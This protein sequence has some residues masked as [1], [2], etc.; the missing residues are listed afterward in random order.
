MSKQTDEQL[1]ESMIGHMRQDV[2]ST[3]E[4]D[5]LAR[6]LGPL[7]GP[8]AG[9]PGGTSAH[10][11]GGLETVSGTV[12]AV[13]SVSGFKIAATAAGLAAAAAVGG[14]YAL[15]DPTPPHVTTKPA[16]VPSG[17]VPP[18][19]RTSPTPSINRPSVAPAVEPPTK[20]EVRTTKKPSPAAKQQESVQAEHQLL[21]EARAVL[22]S[23]PARALKLTRQ[24]LEEF[25]GGLL[26]QE[27]E[28]IA[29]DAL[30]AL[31]R[32]N[33]AKARALRFAKAYPNSYF[34]Q[35]LRAR[36]VIP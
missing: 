13:G 24:H 1:L 26:A 15:S 31:G 4:V 25:P 12:G 8:G 3:K 6:G 30:L 11:T 29:I 35:R 7:L 20:S 36:K 23:N 34:T 10:P 22:G 21:A 32:N 5:A 9:P 2:L 16:A 28:M 17:Q 19:H 18:E 33:P 27:R 14:Y